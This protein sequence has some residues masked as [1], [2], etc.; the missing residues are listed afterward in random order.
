VFALVYA[1]RGRRPA[2][3]ARVSA[4][5]V[6]VIHREGDKKT[7]TAQEKPVPLCLGDI[8]EIETGSARVETAEGDRFEFEPGS[9]LA[10]EGETGALAWKFE[11]GQLNGNFASASTRLLVG[12][13]VVKPRAGSSLRVRGADRE[14]NQEIIVLSKLNACEILVPKVLSLSFS[15]GTNTQAG[16]HTGASVTSGIAGFRIA[17]EIEKAADPVVLTTLRDGKAFRLFE[18]AD[19]LVTD[20]GVEVKAGKVESPAKAGSVTVAA[21]TPAAQPG[22]AKP[23]PDPGSGKGTGAPPDVGP[24][25]PDPSPKAGPIP[26]PADPGP[27]TAPDPVVEPGGPQAPGSGP[28]PGPPAAQPAGSTPHAGTPPAPGPDPAQ[29]A[30]KP[31]ADPTAT[32]PAGTLPGP[33][34]VEAKEPEPKPPAVDPEPPAKPP[35]P[36]ETVKPEPPAPRPPAPRIGPVV[37]P[38]VVHLKGTVTLVRDGKPS[39]I[40]TGRTKLCKGDRIRVGSKA[41][42]V[43]ETRGGVRYQLEEN[44]EFVYEE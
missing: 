14:G 29:P 9:R 4:F 33:G 2:E 8:L 22:P 38:A 26:A 28:D 17:A 37:L 10:L 35:D 11:A 30:V 18:D 34:V 1:L 42:A 36:A 23:L 21:G 31:P 12:P 6:L 24:P 13:F 20:A 19:L 25:A 7:F 3:I 40:A 27:K 43:V 5:K 16:S 15:N 41:R 39:T 44:S 32:A